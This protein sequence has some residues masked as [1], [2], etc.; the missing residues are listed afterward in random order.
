MAAIVN[1]TT[2]LA[3]YNL[4]QDTVASILG[5][6][7]SGYGQQVFSSPISAN[8]I[9]SQ[10][11]WDSLKADIQNISTHTGS[12]I[13]S[14]TTINEHDMISA[15]AVDSYTSAVFGLSYDRFNVAAGNYLTTT[16][17]PTGEFLQKSATWINGSTWDK[18][19]YCDITVTFPTS[20]DARYFFNSGG[21]L[22]INISRVPG[23]L[24][25]A[26]NTS[27][28]SLISALSE[29]QI[30]GQGILNFYNLTSTF[31]RLYS[32]F[33]VYPY[34]F[35]SVEVFV[36]SNSNLQPNI[37]NPTIPI[38][39]GNI[40]TIRVR[41]FDRYSAIGNGVDGT[42]AV[43]VTEK[44]ATGTLITPP[45]YT[46]LPI[47]FSINRPSYVMSDIIS[48]PGGDLTV[49]PQVSG[50]TVT[51]LQD[52]D[53]FY[54]IHTFT[55]N[56]TLTITQNPNASFEYLIVG[57]GGGG[58]GSY[59]YQDSP[60][61]GFAG[62]GLITERSGGG[63]GGGG[64]LY[65]TTTKVPGAYPVTV[66]A[67]GSKGTGGNTTPSAGNN[68]GNSS[69]FGFT[70]LGGGGGGSGIGSGS[71]ANGKNGGNGGGGGKMSSVSA[72]SYGGS[73][74][75]GQGNNGT[76]GNFNA[77]AGGGT[78]LTSTISG[79]S[80]LYSLSV[81]QNSGFWSEIGINTTTP[82]GNGNPS[83]YSGNPG[84]VIV[85]YRIA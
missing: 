15:S 39:Y 32:K 31:T 83:G 17:S 26:Q 4:I 33:N 81:I 35:N 36:K 79:Q 42:F 41:L 12:A 61:P 30:S 66:G 11:H 56:G 46:G 85:R 70:A 2:S 18:E 53:N 84:V 80:A 28:A 9:I 21:A 68:G 52:G 40:I 74:T 58:G 37:K 50:G 38:D 49:Y 13:G 64:V 72:I 51:V 82:N 62:T 67:S 47:A 59:F 77:G 73:G 20:N 5:T 1:N 16:Y 7:G 29:I 19:I 6:G 45:N 22:T 54:R 75:A 43:L 48:V 71:T 10:S 34:E 44:R 24:N 14:I 25:N 3:E 60:P 76:N 55:T 63:G 27:W 69:V 78:A 8:S 65:G 23:T 57:G